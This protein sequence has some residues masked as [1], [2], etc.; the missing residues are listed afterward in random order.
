MNAPSLNR[1]GPLPVATE[2]EPELEPRSSASQ[3]ALGDL[4]ELCILGVGS[5]GVVSLVRHRPDGKTYG[6]TD[7]RLRRDRQPLHFMPYLW[8]R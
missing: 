3:I 2:P 8:R 5:F 4:E 6:E 7:H 1:I